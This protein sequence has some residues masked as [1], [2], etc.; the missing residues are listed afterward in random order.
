F[1]F[2]YLSPR[3]VPHAFLRVCF[4]WDGLILIHAVLIHA[5][6]VTFES[7]YVRGP[8]PTELVQPGIDLPKWFRLEAVDS[9]LRIYRRFDETRLAQHSQVF[10]HRWLRH[11]KLTFNFSN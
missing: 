5:I 9:A 6:E 8:E 10:R 4:G 3:F 2:S 7:I 11:T 1:R